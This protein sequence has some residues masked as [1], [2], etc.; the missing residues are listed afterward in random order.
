TANDA[1]PT[2]G[3][4]IFTAY[5]LEALEGGLLGASKRVT[6][7]S[8]L[9]VYIQERMMSCPGG[10]QTPDFGTFDHDDRGEMLISLVPVPAGAQPLPS[11]VAFRGETPAVVPPIAGAGK[12][13]RGTAGAR[14]RGRRWRG[15]GRARTRPP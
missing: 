10:G 5:L 4:S 6:T 3:H 12:G 9:A 14:G 11:G 2:P 1:G 15:V 8:G 13:F 7:G